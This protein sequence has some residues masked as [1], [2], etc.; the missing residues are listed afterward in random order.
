MIPWSVVMVC[1]LVLA[2]D[3][4]RF[5]DRNSRR[6]R[7]SCFRFTRISLGHS[8]ELALPAPLGTTRASEA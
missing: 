5:V 3:M 2:R 7:V 4:P 1:G 8:D 6:G